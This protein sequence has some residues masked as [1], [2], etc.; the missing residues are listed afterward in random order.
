MPCPSICRATMSAIF[1]YPVSPRAKSLHRDRAC[2]A[3]PL[4][5]NTTISGESQRDVMSAG[6]S[7]AEYVTLPFF[8]MAMPVVPP[9]YPLH[10][11]CPV[12][13]DPRLRLAHQH[14]AHF[15]PGRLQHVDGN[16]RAVPGGKEVAAWLK[17]RPNCCSG[18][19]D[20]DEQW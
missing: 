13:A 2:T 4:Q 19:R 18:C 8:T 15:Q 20:G 16:T 9:R 17:R 5:R 6:G 12:A 3:L 7:S 10:R 1:S 11:R 14:M